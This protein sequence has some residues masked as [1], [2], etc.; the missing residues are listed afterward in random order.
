[1]EELV[2]RALDLVRTIRALVP[3]RYPLLRLALPTQILALTS[4]L[5]LGRIFSVERPSF[6]CEIGLVQA[7]LVLVLGEAGFLGLF[8]LLRPFAGEMKLPGYL[9]RLLEA[10]RKTTPQDLAITCAL[11]GFV[12][13]FVFRGI[14]LPLIGMVL[15]AAVFSAAHRPRAAFHWLTLAGLAA[16]F[17]VEVRYTGGLL[18]PMIH[19]ALHDLMALGVLAYVVKNDPDSSL[20]TM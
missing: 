11:V 5:I 16:L 19:H 1:M 20:F 12:E 4:A 18:V 6:G 2:R 3:E 15:S 7:G 10:L 17:T 13:E 14:L 9:Y 8:M